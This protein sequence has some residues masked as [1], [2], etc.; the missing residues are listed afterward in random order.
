M[1]F[2]LNTLKFILKSTLL[3]LVLPLAFI[4]PAQAGEYS[5]QYRVTFV[6]TWTPDSH[7]TDF[8]GGAHFSPLIGNT[9]NEEGFIWQANEIAT[10]AIRQ[11][12]ETGGTSLLTNEINN[13]IMNTASAESLIRGSGNIGAVGMDAIEFD[14]SESHPLFSIVTMIAPS[15]DWFVGAHGIDL[16]NNNGV[17]ISELTVDLLPYDAGTD[18]GST[19]TSANSATSPRVPIQQ[20]NQSPLPGNVPLGSLI[21]ELISTEGSPGFIFINGFE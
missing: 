5:A 20:I 15:P 9:H 10:N 19:F 4:V 13:M 12:A 6:G 14:V 17:W 7:P 11:M 21:F 18:S 3:S 1:K 8:P 2:T 16:L